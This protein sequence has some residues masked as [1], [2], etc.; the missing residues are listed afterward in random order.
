MRWS[1][2][3]RCAC[4]SHRHP[5]SSSTQFQVA[6]TDGAESI[7]TVQTV[8]YSMDLGTVRTVHIHAHPCGYCGVKSTVGHDRPSRPCGRRVRM[9]GAVTAPDRVAADG[10]RGTTLRASPT[11]A[12]Q[13]TP[14]PKSS[15]SWHLPAVEGADGGAKPEE[16][17]STAA[18]L[19]MQS[20]S[21][22]CAACRRHQSRPCFRLLEP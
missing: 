1:S 5:T 8:R 3:T 14:Y 15:P 18:R 19:Q 17:S 7:G 11:S 20:L 21:S 12:L 10:E 22:P 13:D 6:V 2:S 4:R 9:P 16:R